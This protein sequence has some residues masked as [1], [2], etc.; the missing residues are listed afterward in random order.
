MVIK[1]GNDMDQLLV[2][3]ERK[4]VDGVATSQ[5]PFMYFCKQKGTGNEFEPVFTIREI[6]AYIGFSKARGEK[7]VVS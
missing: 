3:F 1:E 7:N 4:A 2:L 5:R 6:P